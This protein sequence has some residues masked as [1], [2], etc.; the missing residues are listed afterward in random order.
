MKSNTGKFAEKELDILVKSN[1]D[2]ENRPIVENF[3]PEI[4]ALVDKFGKS[5][6]SGGSAPYS[7]HA[8]TKTIEK[9]CLQKSICPITGI[10]EEWV[11]VA[12]LGSGESNIMYQNNRCSALFKTAEGESWYLDAISWRTEKGHTYNGSALMLSTG[13]KIRSRQFIK[14]FPFEPKTFIIDIIEKEVKPDD[15]EFFIKDESQLEEVFEV[16]ESL[17]VERKVM[18]EKKHKFLL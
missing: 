16:Y 2:P 12:K 14:K 4:L 15:W 3:I 1:T 10:D 7:V 17:K 5:G 6:Q 18:I 9:L 13:Q 11:N 8:L